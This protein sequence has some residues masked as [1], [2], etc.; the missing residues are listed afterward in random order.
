MLKFLNV[1]NTFFLKIFHLPSD[2]LKLIRTSLHWFFRFLNMLFNGVNRQIYWVKSSKLR[3]LILYYI[4][5]QYF[6]RDNHRFSR[7]KFQRS[8]FFELIGLFSLCLHQL[9]K[10]FYIGAS[11]KICEYLNLRIPSTDHCRIKVDLFS[12]S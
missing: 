2:R 10:A 11:P 12:F 4:G 8:Q 6:V 7:F 1:W 9:L 3:I 5:K